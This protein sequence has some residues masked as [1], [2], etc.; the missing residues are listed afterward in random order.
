MPERDLARLTAVVAAV[1]ALL[2]RP[3]RITK[4]ALTAALATPAPAV[5]DFADDDFAP[6]DFG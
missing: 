2:Q 3:G 1:N 4:A 5:D 6:T